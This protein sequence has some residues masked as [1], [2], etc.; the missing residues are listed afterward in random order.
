MN[1]PVKVRGHWVVFIEGKKKKFLT[2]AAALDAL[3]LRDVQL[4][5]EWIVED[6]IVEEKSPRS[7]IFGLFDSKDDSSNS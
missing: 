6:E 1:E 4:E 5:I 7:G 3:G 2:E